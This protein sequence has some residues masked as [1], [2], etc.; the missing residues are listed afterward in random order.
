M[1]G[2]TW[3]CAPAWE[4]CEFNTPLYPPHLLTTISN[5]WQGKVVG[6]P[7]TASGHVAKRQMDVAKPKHCI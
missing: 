4:S 3:C 7:D 1:W 2:C 6:E 5:G